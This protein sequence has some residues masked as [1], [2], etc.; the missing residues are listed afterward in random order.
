[1]D[2]KLYLCDIC[3]EQVS[4]GVESI[5]VFTIDVESFFVCKSC[6]KKTIKKSWFMLSFLPKNIKELFKKYELYD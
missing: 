5:F 2:A 4:E 1:M 3:G 6:L